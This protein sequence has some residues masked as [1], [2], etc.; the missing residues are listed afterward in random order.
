MRN[1]IAVLVLT[2][3]HN[4]NGWA[5]KSLDAT[6][7]LASQL[8]REPT[9]IA[10]NLPFKETKIGDGARRELAADILDR[11]ISLAAPDALIGVV[12]PQSFLDS[13]AAEMSPRDDPS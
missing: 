4:Q 6:D 2:D 12:L 10:T 13:T 3:L 5:V 1:G 8:P 9:I 11:L 7:V